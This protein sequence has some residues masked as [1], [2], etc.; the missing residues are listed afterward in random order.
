MDPVLADIFRTIPA[1][2]A[3][4]VAFMQ[5]QLAGK[6]VWAGLA[7]AHGQ[8]PMETAIQV[9]RESF[10]AAA[11]LLRLSRDALGTSEFDEVAAHRAAPG[12]HKVMYDADGNV[13]LRLVTTEE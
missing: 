10:I 3:A 13:Q 12:R 11:Q 7:H 4:L 8:I 5:R 1:D 9:E 2:P 6:G